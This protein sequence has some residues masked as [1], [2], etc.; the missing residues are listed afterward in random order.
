MPWPSNEIVLELAARV[1]LGLVPNVS[2]VTGLGRVTGLTSG[3]TPADIWPGAGI[4]PWIVTPGILRLKSTSIEDAVGGAGCATV[5]VSGLNTAR[6]L[7]SETVT[8]QGATLVDTVNSYARINGMLG[9]L[10]G[11]A[12][13]EVTNVGDITAQTADGVVRS[14]APAGEGLA[15]MSQYTPPVNSLLLLHSVDVQMEASSGSTERHA[16]ATIW[17]RNTTGGQIYR[18]PRRITVSNS[19][20]VSELRPRMLIGVPGGTDM[21]I[22]V[23][24]IDS[25]SVTAF[26]GAWEGLLLQNTNLR[27]F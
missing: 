3:N 26:T 11:V 2:R 27:L 18:R 15:Q 20:G 14:F 6:G 22:R 7:I 21:Q 1:Q 17:L 24:S 8:L 10:P 25:A 23:I 12:G 19:S 16:D 4:Y 5:L 9:M 13:A